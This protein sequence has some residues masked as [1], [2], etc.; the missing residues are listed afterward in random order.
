VLSDN[1]QCLFRT[2]PPPLALTL[3]MTEKH[4]KQHRAEIMKEQHCSEL[5]A[6][7]AIVD[8]IEIIVP[9]HRK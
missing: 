9:D 6:I 8:D 1:L 2:I 3:A 4:E 7:F 5:E